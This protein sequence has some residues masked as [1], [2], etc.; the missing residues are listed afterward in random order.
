VGQGYLLQQQGCKQHQ[1]A[2]TNFANKAP[3]QVSWLTTYCSHT[4]HSRHVG[5]PALQ[6][7]GKSCLQ[8]ALTAYQLLTW[9]RIDQLHRW[10]DTWLSEHLVLPGYWHTLRLLLLLLAVGSWHKRQAAIG[11]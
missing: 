7:Y 1:V 3:F 10:L 11:P 8:S 2:H 6:C 9:H 5:L 4:S